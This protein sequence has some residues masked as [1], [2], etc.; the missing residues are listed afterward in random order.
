[1]RRAAR[2]AAPVDPLACPRGR[3]DAG[4]L[5][6]FLP[7]DRATLVAIHGAAANLEGW[8]RWRASVLSIAHVIY[9]G[10]TV[11][12]LAWLCTRWVR[13]SGRILSLDVPFL[14]GF[15]VFEFVGY[16]RNRGVV[17]CG[18]NE[19]RYV[20]T[21]MV[22][23]T[24]GALTLLAVP[25]A[26]IASAWSGFPSGAGDGVE[27]ARRIARCATL[28][29]VAVGTK[30]LL[31]NPFIPVEGMFAN[32]LGVIP[33]LLVVPA[34]ICTCL[35]YLTSSPGQERIPLVLTLVVVAI[36]AVDVSR[37]PMT[38]VLFSILLLW[39][40]RRG[41]ALTPRGR[42]TAVAAMPAVF[43]GFVVLAALLKVATGIVSESFDPDTAREST[44]A[45][46]ESASYT[47]VY[48]NTCFIEDTFGRSMGY[49]PFVGVASVV[50][51]PVP[52]S[53]W[54][55][56]PTGLSLPLTLARIGEQGVETG[57]SFSPGLVGE[58]WMNGGWPAIWLGAILLGLFLWGLLS[59]LVRLHRRGWPIVGAVAVLWVSTMLQARGDFYTITVRA[60]EYLFGTVL[61]SRFIFGKVKAPPYGPA[62]AG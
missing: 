1:M 53:L 51:G 3:R 49:L 43:L 18:S 15:F 31:G 45:H 14:V 19:D 36:A 13:N 26:A 10:L 27:Q 6:R 57:T 54:P 17:D 50:L 32:Y 55:A 58:L 11:A 52:R 12:W 25:K 28:I 7:V 46:I 38:Y 44:L 2:G 30:L 40:S 23:G 48:E 4:F 61:A 16:V 60:A 24:C 29:V 47:D 41:T 33:M 21:T 59:I 35:V 9:V 62:E 42:L 5:D 37:T 20:W 56:K 34:A 39:V 22:A 8:P